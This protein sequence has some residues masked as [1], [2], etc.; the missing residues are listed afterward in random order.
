[1]DELLD[2]ELDD[3]NSSLNLYHA[4]RAEGNFDL[5]DLYQ[6]Q[7]KEWDSTLGILK[8]GVWSPFYEQRRHLLGR[9]YERVKK[10]NQPV[11][12]FDTDG[13][14]NSIS[15]NRCLDVVAYSISLL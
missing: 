1:M 6:D 9:I 5:A 4:A 15:A 8:D 13:N 12:P 10:F 7:I 14:G 2:Y 3:L 11:K